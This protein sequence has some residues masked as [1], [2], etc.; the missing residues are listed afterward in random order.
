VLKKLVA[1]GAIA[2]A[3]GGAILSA[4]PAQA[5]D[6]DSWAAGN[7][8]AGNFQVLPIQT[9]RGIDAAGIGAAVHTILGVSNEQGPCVNG[10]VT[11]Q[12]Q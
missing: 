11:A 10:P 5:D 7:N 2:A 4:A 8:G 12:G 6:F 9:C 1:A 3:L